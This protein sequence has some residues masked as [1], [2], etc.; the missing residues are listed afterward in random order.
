[1]GSPLGLIGLMVD[2]VYL[3]GFNFKKKY[4]LEQKTFYPS[5]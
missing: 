3:I 5:H 1:M 2:W 4:F